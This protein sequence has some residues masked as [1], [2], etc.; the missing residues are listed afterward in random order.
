MNT[1]LCKSLSYK[2]PERRSTFVL[3]GEGDITFAF[4]N[5]EE[6]APSECDIFLHASEQ[7]EPSKRL[8][9]RASRRKIPP[10]KLFLMWVQL[11]GSVSCCRLNRRRRVRSPPRSSDSRPSLVSIS[12][13]RLLWWFICADGLKNRRLHPRLNLVNGERPRKTNAVICW[14]TPEANSRDGR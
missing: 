1:S 12:A 14:S 5:R 10:S 2:N 7:N 8:R 6:R 3:S 4:H 9:F 13:F 11:F